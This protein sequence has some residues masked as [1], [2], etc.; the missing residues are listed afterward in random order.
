MDSFHYT[1]AGLHCESLPATD[2]AARFSTP[3]YVYSA[4]T[5]I[6]HYDKLAAAFGE[7]SPLI[8]YSIKSCGNTH[9]LRL[10]A[11]RGAGMDVVSGGELARADAAGVPRERVVY[12]GVGKTDA[13]ITAALGFPTSGERQRPVTT[14]P[15]RPVAGARGSSD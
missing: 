15:A 3:T 1:A 10:L 9:I 14:D 6:D 12:A 11:S 4:A 8:C 5:L 13:E 7:L 2:L